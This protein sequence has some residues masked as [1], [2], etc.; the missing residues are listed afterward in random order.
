MPATAPT[1]ESAPAPEVKKGV[2]EVFCV[3]P[4]RVKYKPSV[5]AKVV[6]DVI[7]F[8]DGY[9]RATKGAVVSLDQADAEALSEAKQVELYK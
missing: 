8:D 5:K 3:E 7:W 4:D 6:A 9:S 2:V 1:P